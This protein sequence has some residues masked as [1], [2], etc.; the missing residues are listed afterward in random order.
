MSSTI[1]R[2]EFL[3]RTGLTLA[4]AATPSGLKV[5]AMSEADTEFDVFSPHV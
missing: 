3:T 1:D 4:V 2:R 5:F